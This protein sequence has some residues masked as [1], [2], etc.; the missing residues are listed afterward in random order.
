MRRCCSSWSAGSSSSTGRWD[1]AAG[2]GL[3]EEDYRASA[4]GW[5]REVKG[6][7]EL[8][9]LSRPD[10]VEAA[11]R[12]YS[13][14]G[15]HRRDDTFNGTRISQADYGTE[16]LAYD[17]NVAAAG[18]RRAVDGV[19]SEE[20]AACAGCGRAGPTN[21]DRVSVRDVN[22]PGA[23]GVTFDEL[24]EAYHEQAWAS[25]TAGRT[26]SSW[27]PPST[28]STRR[29]PSSRSSGLR[30]ARLSPPVMAS[31]TITD[32]SGR[33]LS[34]QTVE[35]SGSRSRTRPFSAWASTARSGRRDA[36]ALEE[37]SAW[38]RAS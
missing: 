8:L 17:I 9:N 19:M 3:S 27:R 35:A 28:P 21:K 4:P 24:E 15:R 1:A 31:V 26:C 20:A 25:S 33:N 36:A 13:P 38:R 22:D 14:P 30:G 11:H 5:A 34:G 16:A 32:L 29:P 18:A 37:L 7:H 6:N 12:E 2:R 10:V 23:R